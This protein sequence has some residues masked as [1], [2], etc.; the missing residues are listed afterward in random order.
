MHFLMTWWKDMR[1]D[2]S[3]MSV[4]LLYITC[5]LFRNQMAFWDWYASDSNPF[6]YAS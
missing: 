3:L 2:L 1:F 6:N 4:F 5:G